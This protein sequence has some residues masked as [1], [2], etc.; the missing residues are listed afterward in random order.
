MTVSGRKS[1]R[2]I[3]ML[4]TFCMLLGLL[5]MGVGA[6]PAQGDGTVTDAILYVINDDSELEYNVVYSAPVTQDTQVSG[7]GITSLEALKNALGTPD[8]LGD[9]ITAT[10]T[11]EDGAVTKVEVTKITP[12]P[13]VGISWKRMTLGMTIRALPRPLSATAQLPSSCLRSRRSRR[14]SRSCLNWTVSSSPAARTGI[15]ICM[16]R[17]RAPTAPPAGMMPGIPP[18]CI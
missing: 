17:L 4:L 7:Q 15:L 14:P 3:S 2:L 13:V 11:L 5:T 1:V 6:A 16:T 10:L 18:I 9:A 8:D 12:R